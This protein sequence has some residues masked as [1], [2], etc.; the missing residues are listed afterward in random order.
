MFIPVQQSLRKDRVPVLASFT[1]S[2]RDRD[3]GRLAGRN[4]PPVTIVPV[5]PSGRKCQALRLVFKDIPSPFP[6]QDEIRT[7]SLR[8]FSIR[9]PVTHQNHFLHRL[10]KVFLESIDEARFR[11][12]AP[13]FIRS[14]MRTDIRSVQG[15]LTKNRLIDVFHQFPVKE[16]YFGPSQRS[17]FINQRSEQAFKG[18]S[19]RPPHQNETFSRYRGSILPTTC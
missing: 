5:L 11:F 15:N 19:R 18:C 12:P 6:F 9:I 4:V 7:G 3:N 16:Q 10:G 13:A 8:T 17:V 14:Y 1:S 2:H